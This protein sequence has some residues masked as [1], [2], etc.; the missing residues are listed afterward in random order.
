[1]RQAMM[2][3]ASM[4]SGS[5]NVPRATPAANLGVWATPRLAPA[6]RTHSTAPHARP[7]Q[8]RRG[9]RRLRFGDTSQGIRSCLKFKRARSERPQDHR[10][11]GPQDHGTTGLQDHRTTGPQD[12]RTTGP[13]DHR[14]TRPQDYRTT[15]PQDYRTTGLV[16]WSV[17]LWSRGPWWS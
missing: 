12:H 4:M 2:P 9:N 13:Q 15:R 16:S 14:T 10:T 6:Q 8:Q 17:V 11:T 7:T 5:V 3:E 1:M